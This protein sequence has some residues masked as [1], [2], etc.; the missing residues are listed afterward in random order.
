[1]KYDWHEFI[2]R[3]AVSKSAK[4]IEVRQP[5]SGLRHNKETIYVHHRFPV[6]GGID[7]AEYIYR[8]MSTPNPIL[9]YFKMEKRNDRPNKHN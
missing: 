6:K 4:S 8:I 2:A 7:E 1:M 3:I 9:E 5:I